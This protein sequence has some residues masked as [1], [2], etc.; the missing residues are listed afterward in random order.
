MI[1]E[2]DPP[3]MGQLDHVAWN[4]YNASPFLED[5]N[6]TSPLQKGGRLY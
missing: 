6:S 1:K 3:I 2:S 5:N 4:H